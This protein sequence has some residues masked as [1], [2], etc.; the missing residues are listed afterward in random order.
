MQDAVAGANKHRREE[1]RKNE[2]QHHGRWANP[3]HPQ[4]TGQASD[5]REHEMP[6]LQTRPVRLHSPLPESQ[7]YGH[8]VILYLG[9]LPDKVT[10]I[11]LCVAIITTRSKQPI[12]RMFGMLTLSTTWLIEVDS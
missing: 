9:P 10:L 6:V 8:S 3:R 7:V 4:G 1:P 5:C 2:R 11:S 12:Y